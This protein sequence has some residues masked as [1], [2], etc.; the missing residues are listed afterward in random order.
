VEIRRLIGDGKDA[1]RGTLGKY[2]LS[3]VEL[4]QK[5]EDSDFTQPMQPFG[6]SPLSLPDGLQRAYE[7]TFKLEM[8][9]VLLDGKFDRLDVSADG[10]A[11]VAVDYKTGFVPPSKTAPDGVSFQLPLYVWALDQLFGGQKLNVGGV[12][13]SLTD[14]KYLAGISR[15]DVLK[16]KKNYNHSPRP[17]DENEWDGFM[18]ALARQIKTIHYLIEHGQ[19]P[20]SVRDER[21]AKCEFCDFKNICYRNEEQQMVRQSALTGEEPIYTEG[22]KPQI[23]RGSREVKT[24]GA[25]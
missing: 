11:V 1:P 15:P 17:L 8:N 6:L 10:R 22:L 4:R 23:E 3:E 14:Y 2:L 20:I 7:A 5:W 21:N 19:F 13:Y 24:N 25:K 12:F 9:G 16:K 18:E